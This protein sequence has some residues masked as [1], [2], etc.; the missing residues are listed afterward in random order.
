MMAMLAVGGLR[1]V[2]IADKSRLLPTSGPGESESLMVASS[3][4]LPHVQLPLRVASHSFHHCE[5]GKC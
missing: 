1:V 2:P 5:R 3:P 4:L